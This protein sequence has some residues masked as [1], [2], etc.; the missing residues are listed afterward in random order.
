MEYDLLTLGAFPSINKCFSNNSR[1]FGQS[2]EY[3]LFSD[4]LVTLKICA[5]LQS[6]MSHL[7]A[8]APFTTT[9]TII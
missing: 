4:V 3:D 6:K 5:Q 8:H 9:Y 2:D 7:R 1:F